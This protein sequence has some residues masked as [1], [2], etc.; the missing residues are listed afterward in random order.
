MLLA[1]RMSGFFVGPHGLEAGVR[2]FLDVDLQ[3]HTVLEAH[4]D[5]RAEAVHQSADRAPF[6][7]HG[8]E[9]LAGPPSG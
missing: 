2:E 4:G 7:G 8:Y 1:M 5:G 9:Q 3:G 6:L